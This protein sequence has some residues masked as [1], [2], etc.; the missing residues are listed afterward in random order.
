MH[1][2]VEFDF[3]DVALLEDLRQQRLQILRPGI[4]VDEEMERQLGGRAGQLGLEGL[5]LVLPALRPVVLLVAGAQHH[6]AVHDAAFR[7]RLDV[8]V[9]VDAVAV[10]PRIH[11]AVVVGADPLGADR[12]HDGEPP[13]LG[14]DDLRD[15]VQHLREVFAPQLQEKLLVVVLDGGI[16]AVAPLVVLDRWLGEAVEEVAAAQFP[17]VAAAGQ[18]VAADG[19]RHAVQV[20][21]ALE[22]FSHDSLHALAVVAVGVVRDA[23]RIAVEV[24]EADDESPPAGLVAPVAAV[25]GRAVADALAGLVALQHDFAGDE[26]VDR[27]AVGVGGLGRL[28]RLGLRDGPEVARELDDR[29]VDVEVADDDVV[30]LHAHLEGLVVADE[31]AVVRRRVDEEVL[32]GQRLRRRAGQMQPHLADGAVEI[33]A[34]AVQR[35]PVA[36]AVLE[37]DA[38]VHVAVGAEVG[39]VLR[40]GIAAGVAR[41]VKKG[42]PVVELHPQLVADLD[43]FRHHVVGVDGLVELHSP[44]VVV[45][46]R[47]HP[48]HGGG[49]VG[50]AARAAEVDAPHARRIGGLQTVAQ[51][52]LRVV[53]AP[54]G[55]EAVVEKVNRLPDHD[56]LLLLGRREKARAKTPDDPK[57]P[58]HVVVLLHS[59]FA[60][61]TSSS[62]TIIVSD[63]FVTKINRFRWRAPTRGI[64]SIARQTYFSQASAPTSTP[65]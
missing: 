39:V 34:R 32:G 8:K 30:A 1:L 40:T 45:A 55:E 42:V 41:H 62:H 20:G 12:R 49:I 47:V 35:L 3:V 24:A 58:T 13:A 37:F 6:H 19:E 59:V 7:P 43:V 14:V 26:E 60:P 17:P 57:T 48:P 10:E 9:V 4:V 50:H 38:G 29:V 56:G 53:V 46:P 18:R 36:H 33:L 61:M 2:L 44:L 15:A 21:I 65:T 64:S 51:L 31:V 25:A 63:V 5:D 52:L 16:D 54:L 23:A 28:G 27:L 22:E 11:G